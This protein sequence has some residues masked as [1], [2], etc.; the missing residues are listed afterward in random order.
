[1]KN[2]LVID[3]EM[4]ICNNI[5]AILTDEGFNIQIAH[6]SDDAFNYIHNNSYNLIILD[7]WLDNSKYDGLEILKQIRQNENVPIIVIS[8][9]GNIDMAVSA[10]KDGANEFIE[11]PFNTERLLLSVNRSIEL[12]EVK[13]ENQ[14]LKEGSIFDYEFIGE[15]LA[16]TKIRQQIIKI[17]P[18]LSRVMIYGESGTGKDLSLI[19]I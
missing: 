3:D 14:L 11:K 13:Y 2:I 1:M 9:H 5:K 17:A 8:G 18:T 16:I 19:H 7:V 10:I 6:N 15:S 4:D 12:H